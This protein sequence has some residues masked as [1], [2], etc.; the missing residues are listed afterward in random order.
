MTPRRFLKLDDMDLFVYDNLIDDNIILAIERQVRH[1]RYSSRHS[2]SL[3]SQQ[4]REW[5]GHFDVEDFLSHPVCFAAHQGLTSLYPGVNFELWDV[6]CNNTIFGDWA[7]AH[8]DSLELGEYSALYYANFQWDPD[9]YGETVFFSQGEPVVSISTRPGR[10]VLFD[11]RIEHRAGVP[12]TNCP[13]Q[14]LTLSL[15]FAADK[16][17]TCSIDMCPEIF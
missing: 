13:E 16:V 6:H 5:A 3:R 11:S 12:A 17:G 2:S 1:A 14:R 4:F 10:L 15:R 8:R 9:W 7:F